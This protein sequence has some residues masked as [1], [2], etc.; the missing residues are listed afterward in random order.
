MGHVNDSSSALGHLD[1]RDRRVIERILATVRHEQRGRVVLFGSRA[2]NDARRSS[3][4]D[5]AIDALQP[6]PPH[7]LAQLR[8]A[9]EESRIPFRVDLVD[10]ASAH[11]QLRAAIDAEGIVWPT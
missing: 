7:E 6:L 1:L 4:I 11:P 3:D 5:L 9:F 10:Y 8:E 2:R